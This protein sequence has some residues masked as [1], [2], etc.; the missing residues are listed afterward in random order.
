MYTFSYVALCV[1]RVGGF[2]GKRQKSSSSRSV[3]TAKLPRHKWLKMQHAY[4]RKSPKT[5]TIISQYFKL[6][7]YPEARDHGVLSVCKL[8]NQRIWNL[9]LLNFSIFYV[10]PCFT[11]F[12]LCAKAK[13]R[14]PH[15]QHGEVTTNWG[16]N[17]TRKKKKTQPTAWQGGWS[18]TLSCCTLLKLP[19]LSFLSPQEINKTQP[20]EKSDL[21]FSQHDV[22]GFWK[23]Q[24][25]AFGLFRQKS[26]LHCRFLFSPNK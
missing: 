6:V 18:V 13:Q 14:Y 1:L 15:R 16:V 9:K 22:G 19:S 20:A 23:L 12:H 17:W 2:E 10:F 24:N 25:K 4:V 11:L 8:D 21:H 7:R 5:T 3:N 26:G